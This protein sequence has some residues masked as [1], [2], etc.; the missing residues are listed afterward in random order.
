MK[1][2]ELYQCE[3]CGARYSDKKACEACEESHVKTARITG[4]RYTPNKAGNSDGLP[5]KVTV[6]FENG[7]CADYRR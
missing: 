3:V 4:A 1:K 5:V 2:L 6:L 7:K